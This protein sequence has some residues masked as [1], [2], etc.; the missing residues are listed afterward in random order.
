MLKAID[1]AM[2]ESPR[3]GAKNTSAL[4]NQRC[5]SKFHVDTQARTTK[6]LIESELHRSV[7]LKFAELFCKEA[8][9]SFE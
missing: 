6:I 7:L 8:S 2:V 3:G 9:A 1:R 5:T 4:R